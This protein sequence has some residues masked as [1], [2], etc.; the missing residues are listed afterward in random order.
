MP[1]GKRLMPTKNL[2]QSGGAVRKKR[3]GI[4]CSGV[5][6]QP[7]WSQASDAPVPPGIV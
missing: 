1:F 5:I 7:D 2:D 4:V 3:E 6:L